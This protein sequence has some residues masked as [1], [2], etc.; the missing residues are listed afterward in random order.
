M[1]VRSFAVAL[2]WSLGLGAAIAQ[3]G[4]AYQSASS[5]P[6]A[7]G[8][9]LASC[10]WDRDGSGPLAP[11][12]VL[13][14]VFT[15]L[16]N[17]A[18][19][20]VA[21][22]DPATGDCAALGTGID[23]LS[24]G[25]TQVAALAVTL[26]DELIAAGRFSSA[27]GVVMNH[28]ARWNGT[29]WQPLATG[30]P[31]AVN[32][33]AVLPNGEVVAGGSAAG[34]ILRW[35][36]TTWSGM[37][38]GL[39]AAVNALAV[40]PN[41]DLI[42]GG[43]LVLPG[44][45]LARWNGTNWSPLPGG[46]DGGV[47]ALLTLPAGDL[48]LGGGFANAGG[49]P[50]IGI[51]RWD[52]TT[53]SGLGGGIPNPVYALAQL[54]NGDLVAGGLFQ[55]AGGVS[56]NQVARWN[57]ASWTSIGGGLGLPYSPGVDLP[58]RTLLAAPNG[59]LLAGGMFGS[60]GGDAD[61]VAR[62]DG[63]VW[64][65]LRA[66]TGGV[67]HASASAANGDLLV[68]GE[69]T[70]VEGV[71]ARR[72]A[73]RSGASWQP[74]GS[75]ADAAVYA[76]L[77]LPNGDV[78]IGGSFT[79]VGGVPANRVAR[80]NGASW[81][82][83]G[84]GLPGIVRSLAAGPGGQVLASGDFVDLVAVWDGQ[85][86]NGTG[87]ATG[88]VLTNP[89]ELLP[90]PDGSVLGAVETSLSRVSRWDGFS[91]SPLTPVGGAGGGMVA[92]LGNGDLV[93]AGS[94]IVRRWN[95]TAWATL[96]GSLNGQIHSL[97]ALPNDELLVG[98][99]F[100][101]LGTTTPLARLARW[102]G[103]AWT[104]VGAGANGTVFDL[105]WTLDGQVVAAGAFTQLAGVATGGLGALVTSCPASASSVGAGC[106]GS[107]GANA[108]AASALPWLGSTF[109]SRATG[110]PANGLV[111]EVLGFGQ[112]LQPLVAVL[113]SAGVGCVLATTPDLLRLH[114]PAAN[115]LD[116]ALVLPNVASLIGGTFRQQ[117]VP[118]E[119]DT[120][121]AI[122]GATSSNGLQLTIGAF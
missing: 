103:A 118:L 16:G 17:A 82:A 77:A 93:T 20:G 9:V 11:V 94:G 66:G 99:A 36:G 100:T 112:T 47:L 75:G 34:W 55:S 49:V 111:V 109:P 101:S 13:G 98:G 19:R 42:A 45:Y 33:L 41:G 27:G 43:A 23:P 4:L 7:D 38:G 71:A 108:L 28:V 84:S 63:A 3:C 57:G 68:V 51:A 2:S 81:Q 73:R 1:I 97:L 59:D 15:T 121:G 113:P 91:W 8:A 104:P 117:V 69:F 52:G 62:W 44:S 35:N 72:V 6:D 40:L 56:A 79:N 70:T 95:G 10:L 14:G 106:A 85:S 24:S 88:F 119:L 107:G 37:G 46:V 25:V 67:I 74:L 5:L 53:W 64:R 105:R 102:N 87:I 80:W 61:F 89:R 122:V 96:G 78:V 115:A 76:V 65:Q 86:W 18:S 54:G 50:A 116:L 39:G 114:L 48:L 90:L 32:A 22:F 60:V 120:G 30:V 21:V 12:V 31:F 110:M 92:R 83:I 29:A 58:V 26:N